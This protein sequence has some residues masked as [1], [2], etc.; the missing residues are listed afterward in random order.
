MSHSTPP[1]QFSYANLGETG[2]TSS[3]HMQGGRMRPRATAGTKAVA[4]ATTVTTGAFLRKLASGKNLFL[5][6]HGRVGAGWRDGA[7]QHCS[8]YADIQ[9]AVGGK[10]DD[11]MGNGRYGN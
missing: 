2:Q 5:L 6:L 7:S 3:L 10:F 8:K 9:D 1:G 4:M 11:G